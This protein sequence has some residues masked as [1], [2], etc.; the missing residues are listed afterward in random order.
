MADERERDGTGE[1]EAPFGDV[2]RSD[3]Y[4]E[5]QLDRGTV[6]LA[7][8][9]FAALLVL[10]FLLGH[11]WGRRAS[12]DDA[13]AGAIAA[14]TDGPDA[15]VGGGLAEPLDDEVVIEQDVDVNEPRPITRPAISSNAPA[16][17]APR[18]WC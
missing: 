2:E 1:A 11:W 7:G 17:T 15:S 10:S 18:R 13:A 16:A 3:S 12:G 4:F 5:I 8:L 14:A 9:A 6:A